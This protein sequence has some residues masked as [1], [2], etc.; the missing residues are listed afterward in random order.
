MKIDRVG[1]TDV[2]FRRNGAGSRAVVLVHGFL[3]DQHVWDGVIAELSSED[4]ETVQLDLAG[5]G[6]RTEATG[7][8]RLDRLVS[9]V[10]AVVD[11]LNKPVVLVGQSMAAPIVE[12]VAVA[13]AERT[14]GLVLL[15]PIPLAGTHLPD[16][17]VGT[18]RALGGNPSA[19][20]T[21]RQQLSTG[22]GEADLD[23]LTVVGCRVRT[24]VVSALVDCWDTGHPDG[25]KPSSYTGP[26]LVVRGA[27]DGFVTAEV[28]VRGVLERF[29]D[30]ETV[31]LDGSGHWPHVEQ[32]SAVAALLDTFLTKTRPAGDTSRDVKSQQWT[33]AFAEKSA[34]SF[35]KAFAEEVV[36]DATILTRPIEGRERV[37]QV[38]AAASGIY[39]A[40][41]FT[42]EAT[43]GPRTYLEWKA[44]AFEGTHIE[45][46]TILTKDEHGRIVR[47]AIHHRPLGATL[48]FSAEL[49]DRLLGRIDPTHFHNGDR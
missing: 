18:F 29:G 33:T 15:A 8:F 27:D 4:V 38:M 10:I 36:L 24:E 20:R 46:V 12:L 5:L 17:T 1:D 39:D 22:L 48:R 44:A 41:A 23:R 7:P 3:D 13:R 25:E 19:Q 43:Q 37:Q 49:R 45:G 35:G 30:V 32:S 42:H 11:A 26:V 34:D 28:V 21:L 9:E 16:E 40:L 31:T 6:E 47:V 2:R 14:L